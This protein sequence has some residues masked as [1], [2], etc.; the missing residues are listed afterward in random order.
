MNLGAG[1]AIRISTP[2]EE[3]RAGVSRVTADVDGTPLWF[4]SPDAELAPRPEA[5][6][7]A[8]L[9]SSQHRGRPLVSEG[10]LSEAWMENAGEILRK[11][12]AWWGY[13]PRRPIADVHPDDDARGHSRALM[14][15]AGVD[16]YHSLLT[17]P[18]PGVL[19]AV[20]GFD[21]T[22]GDVQRMAGLRLAVDA[23]ATAHNCLPVVVRTNL[24]EHPSFGKPHTWERA[25]GGALVA[26]GHLLSRQIGEQVISSSW[27]APIE[28][29]WGSHS[30]TDPLFAANGF[31]VD[32]FGGPTRRESKV[33]AVAFDPLV[34]NHLRVC[35][36]NSSA[37]GNCSRCEK[38]VVTMLHLMENAVLGEFQ[39]FDS[40]DMQSRI[41]A[42]PFI[43]HNLN[44]AARIVERHIVDANI[45]RALRRA[46]KRSQLAEPLLRMRTHLRTAVDRCV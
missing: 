3:R 18:A 12:H 4:E 17:G 22:L 36:K 24:R 16:S 43:Q 40:S 29:P 5:F 32:H 26:I 35:W 15:S 10:A 1:K 6:A 27:F 44:L 8:L 45:A 25:H 42:L 30:V 13:Q 9:L 2:R 19:I 31:T 39:V 46:I 20:H 38:C 34:R 14:F 41:D 37:V 28:Q 23:T 21:I 7:S 11:W 33:A